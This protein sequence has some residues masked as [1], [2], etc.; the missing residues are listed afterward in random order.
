M[1]LYL[2]KNSSDISKEQNI[3]I[4]ELCFILIFFNAFVCSLHH[5]LSSKHKFICIGDWF[6]KQTVI[7]RYKAKKTDAF[8]TRK[9]IFT[10]YVVIIPKPYLQNLCGFLCKGPHHTWNSGSQKTGEWNDMI[11]WNP[12]IPQVYEYSLMVIVIRLLSDEL[13][14]HVDDGRSQEQME[15]YTDTSK[16]EG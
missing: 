14:Q 13:N 16:E 3:Y 15:V 6:H 1:G 10:G 11:K 8:S 12:H 2:F 9:C 7:V 4:H 5:P